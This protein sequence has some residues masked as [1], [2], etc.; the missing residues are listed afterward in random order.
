MVNQQV[1]S[2]KWNEIKGELK[3]KWGKLTDED[4]RSFSGN[5]DQ[6]VGKIQQRTGESRDTIEQYLGQFAQEGSEFLSGLRD[7]LEETAEQTMETARE[8]YDN[9]R[10]GYSEAEKVVQHRPGQAVAVAFGVGLL[11][12][13]GIALLLR[14]RSHDSRVAQTRSAA[15]HI[16]KQILDTVTS[17]FPESFSKR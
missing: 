3:K 4:L 7:R 12:G 16:G 17:M 2:G 5:I 15:E 9:L 10:R 11:S 1:L 14:E 8:G 6:L 13:I